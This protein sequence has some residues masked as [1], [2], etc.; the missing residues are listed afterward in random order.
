MIFQLPIL[1]LFAIMDLH[2]YPNV[3]TYDNILNT[4]EASRYFKVQLNNYGR[5]ES[6]VPA[7]AT[8]VLRHSNRNFNANAI[9]C[10]SWLQMI[11]VY[12]SN[13]KSSWCTYTNNM[14]ECGVTYE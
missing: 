1:D 8:S 9:K 13:N 11:R 14:I 4:N 2:K 7:A 5:T 3:R 10:I 6:S 12:T